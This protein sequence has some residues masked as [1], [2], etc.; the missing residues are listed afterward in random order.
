MGVFGDGSYR[1]RPIF[2]DDFAALAVQQGK[3]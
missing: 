3:D 2:V 1:L